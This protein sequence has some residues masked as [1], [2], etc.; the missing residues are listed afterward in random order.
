MLKKISALAL[1]LAA[2]IG[3]TT[4]SQALLGMSAPLD[5]DGRSTWGILRKK[6]DQQLAES[7]RR[8]AGQSAYS[9]NTSY[10]ASTKKLSNYI[11]K[12]QKLMQAQKAAHEAIDHKYFNDYKKFTDWYG[13]TV[14]HPVDDGT[15]SKL[16]WT[17][18]TFPAVTCNDDTSLQD[19]QNLRCMRSPNANPYVGKS[20]QDVLAEQHKLADGSLQTSYPR[21]SMSRRFGNRSPY[22][23]PMNAMNP[24]YQQQTYKPASGYGSDDGATDVSSNF[25]DQD[26]NDD[27]YIDSSERTQSGMLGQG[28]YW[29]QTLDRNGDGYIDPQE[30]QSGML[31]QGGYGQQSLDLN[32][33]GLIDPQERSV[34][35]SPQSRFN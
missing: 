2:T 21:Q 12:L 13:H 10:R 28:R 30:R 4:E 27:G 33:D 22:S 8:K 26:L 3:L 31:E 23:Q 11:L 18:P 15:L 7:A 16:A 5:N 6:N 35:L 17:A 29:Q 25:S 34:G 14:Q 1:T 32:G 24:G 20:T 9:Y 19:I